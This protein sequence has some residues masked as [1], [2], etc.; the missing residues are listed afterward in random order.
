MIA[1]FCFFAPK[2]ADTKSGGKARFD[3]KKMSSM[4]MG[5]LTQAFFTAVTQNGPT[6]TALQIFKSVRKFLADS[7]YSQKP[8]LSTGRMMCKWTWNAVLAVILAADFSFSN[9]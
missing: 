5:A 6:G 2:R 1:N 4:P 8:Q 7:Q 3:G 9:Q